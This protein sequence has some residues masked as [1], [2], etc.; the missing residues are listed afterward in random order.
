MTRLVTFIVLILFFVFG[1]TNMASSKTFEAFIDITQMLVFSNYIIFLVEII[2]AFIL[3]LRIQIF[4]TSRLNILVL[5]WCFYLILNLLATSQ[6]FFVELRQVL[7]WPS[8]FFLF[9]Y[10]SYTDRKNKIVPKIIKILPLII[11]VNFVIFFLISYTQSTIVL[12]LDNDKNASINQIYFVLL[13]LPFVLLFKKSTWKFSFLFLILLASIYSSKRTAMVI[14]AGT[15][16]IYIYLEYYKNIHKNN[17]IRFFA[18]VFIILSVVF[19]YNKLDNQFSGYF[20]KRFENTTEDQGSG[21]LIAYEKTYELIEKTN[22]L[23]FI[24]GSGHDAVRK[25]E[26]V[27]VYNDIISAH[28]DFLEVL[29]DYGLIGFFLYILIIISM[30][31]QTIKLKRRTRKYY[32]ASVVFIWIF[33]IMSLL[34]HLIIYPTYFIYLVSF[35]AITDGKLKNKNH[36]WS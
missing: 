4:L 32:I 31:K 24:I 5:I 10:I 30:I 8:I 11:I 7:F 6:Y 34:S 19:V 1:I 27:E 33:L 35:W 21:R 12:K 17:V 18:P 9:Y 36:V 28:N 25:S 15:I 3:F 20:S 16:L 29:Y 26:K 23:E 22:S 2:A 14:S 13:F